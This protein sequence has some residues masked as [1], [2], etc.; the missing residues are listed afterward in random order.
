MVHEALP[1]SR[2]KNH[3]ALFMFAGCSPFLHEFLVSF[4]FSNSVK[5]NLRYAKLVPNYYMDTP[6]LGPLLRIWGVRRMSEI[7]S[8]LISGASAAV[9]CTSSEEMMQNFIVEQSGPIHVEANKY[10]NFIY[11]N[12]DTEVHDIYL[13]APT[14]RGSHFASGFKRLQTM[15]YKS[16]IGTPIYIP[17]TTKTFDLNLVKCIDT[18]HTSVEVALNTI[19]HFTV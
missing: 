19:K 5:H 6:F 11:S 17:L 10:I 9:M 3:A 4:V 14:E 2:K 8:V 16:C 1:A 12:A 15:L 13:V 18:K 7:S